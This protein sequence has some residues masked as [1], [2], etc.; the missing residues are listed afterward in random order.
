MSNAALMAVSTQK[1]FSRSTLDLKNA[2]P[3]IKLT[4][5]PTRRDLEYQLDVI[6]DIYKSN[7]WTVIGAFNS[8]PFHLRYLSYML[9]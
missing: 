4:A 2:P 8:E 1:Y 9:Q 5:I 6:L 3:K 7:E